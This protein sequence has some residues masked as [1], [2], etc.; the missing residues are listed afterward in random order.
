M[1]NK[2]V[3]EKLKPETQAALQ[4]AADETG[5]ACAAKSASL[6]NFYFEELAKHGMKVEPAGPEFLKELQTIGAK[7]TADWLK[8]TGADGKA[9]VEAYKKAK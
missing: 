4:K 1:V 7:M 3:W 9:I 2:G 6:A 8:K 5:K